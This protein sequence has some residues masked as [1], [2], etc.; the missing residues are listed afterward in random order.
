MKT[1]LVNMASSPDFVGDPKNSMYPYSL[2][3]VASYMLKNGEDCTILDLS[4]TGDFRRVFSDFLQENPYGLIGFTCTAENRFMVIDLIRDAKVLLPDSIIVVGGKFFTYTDQ[5]CLRNV[6]E[7]DYV[8]RDEGEVTFLEL[9]RCLESKGNLDEVAGIT[10]RK[11]GEIRRNPKRPP[12]RDLDEVLLVDS[13][14]DRVVNPAGEYSHFMRMRNFEGRE[15]RCLPIHV[16]RGCP[17]KCAFCLYHKWM[18]RGRT[19]DSLLRE[20]KAKMETY[21]CNVFH[22][23][24]P[25]LL[26]R[27]KFIEDFYARVKE[28]KLDIKFYVETRVDIDL[29][30]VDMLTEIGCI[31]MDFAIESA[32]PKVIGSIRKN[33]EISDAVALLKRARKAGVKLK[34]FSMVSLPDE[35]TEDL[36]M[37][38]DFLKKYR[39]YIDTFSGGI[40]RIYPGTDLERMAKERGLLPEDFDWYDREYRNELVEHPDFSRY[41]RC[42]DVPVWIE[43]LSP[44]EIFAHK[45]EIEKLTINRFPLAVLLVDRVSK[46]WFH[47]L[48]KW[49]PEDVALKKQRLRNLWEVTIRKVKISV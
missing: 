45:K 34:V 30:Y 7:V 14:Y 36:R 29:R 44:E 26:K 41:L 31:S 9:V 47:A 25:H 42:P 40:T 24:D 6:P 32:S 46:Y 48:F 19:A 43:H 49:G 35:T 37:T 38:T 5:E 13:V 8:V 2:L 16:G 28:E 22:F 23:D 4:T 21:E 10:L 27:K 1:L 33:I 18:Y 12:V 3:F 39:K 11:N 20:V 17:G 15:L